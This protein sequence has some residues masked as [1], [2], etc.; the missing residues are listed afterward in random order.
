MGLK[1]RAISVL[2]CNLLLHRSDTGADQGVAR[3][4]AVLFLQ[5]QQTAAGTGKNCRSTPAARTNSSTRY[6]VG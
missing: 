5:K 2:F 1:R 3:V 6:R 4:F